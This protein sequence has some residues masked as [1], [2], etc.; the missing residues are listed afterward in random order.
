MAPS[1]LRKF[2]FDRRPTHSGGLIPPLRLRE[3]G[4][5]RSR[6]TQENVLRPGRHGWATRLDAS[7]IMMSPLRHRWLAACLATLLG[8]VAAAQCV[9]W[10]N[11]DVIQLVRSGLSA[12]VVSARLRSVPCVRFDLSVASLQTL[13]KQ[14][15]PPSVMIAMIEAQ[16][17]QDEAAAKARPAALAST[18]DA[19][20]AWTP[21]QIDRAGRRAL[22]SV[23]SWDEKGTQLPPGHG[24]WVSPTG[25]ILS[26]GAVDARVHSIRVRSAEGDVFDQ[27]AVVDT[28]PRR[29]L[30]VL[31]VN[32][33]GMPALSVD[34]ALRLTPGLPVFA[35]DAVAGAAHV[36][37]GVTEAPLD[38]DLVAGAGSGYHLIPIHIEGLPAPQPIAGRPLL[39]Q[40]SE[41]VGLITPWLW[42][43]ELLALPVTELRGLLRN[44]LG[45]MLASAWPASPP[46]PVAAPA[47]TDP[48]LRM[49]AAQFVFVLDRTHRGLD[50][51]ADDE[52]RKAPHWRVVRDP[53]QADLWLDIT[54]S[55]KGMDRSETLEVF[56]RFSRVLLWTRTAHVAP[57]RR[58]AI[59]RLVDQLV[60]TVNPPR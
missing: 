39:N 57:F 22:L 56:D 48:L 60:H 41:L 31:R 51:R 25:L 11:Q 29:H 14:G 7:V 10:T 3:A 1:T 17:R 27:A 49:R 36:L 43:G 9:P 33:S 38:A 23:E 21:A 59:R 28:D 13:Q 54:A 46:P 42:R 40:K 34:A 24:F 50:A 16:R 44:R 32:A 53:Q 37:T 58:S 26:Y 20:P 5:H 35:V 52:L 47:P 19:A 6:N 4:T 12:G 55:G 2:R 30:S 15:I 45:R 8:T 18:P